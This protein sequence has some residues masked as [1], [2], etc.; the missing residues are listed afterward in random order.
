MKR[1]D[2]AAAILPPRR[3]RPLWLHTCGLVALIFGFLGIPVCI[4]LNISASLAVA[5]GAHALLGVS[6]CVACLLK[7]GSLNRWTR[8]S[9]EGSSYNV[10]PAWILLAG[11]LFILSGS[12]VAVFGQ[13][14][15]GPNAMNRTEILYFGSIFILL[16]LGIGLVAGG[17]LHR[18][19]SRDHRSFSKR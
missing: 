10:A 19:A 2:G 15:D 14:G 13:G 11:A 4:L 9:I 18:R 5:L 6:A 3:E 17:E 12:C 1:S 16:G 8:L 7:Y